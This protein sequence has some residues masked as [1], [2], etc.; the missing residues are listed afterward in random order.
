M[1][2]INPKCSNEN[3][4]KY[5]ILISLHHYQLNLHKERTN[6]DNHEVDECTN[7]LIYLVAFNAF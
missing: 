6:I 7:I 3:S 5:S 4:F 2:T 1:K